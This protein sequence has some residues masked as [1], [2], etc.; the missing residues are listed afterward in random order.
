[1]KISMTP[2]HPGRFI[3]TE[4]LEELGLS[5]TEAAEFMG[6][7]RSTFSDLLHQKAALSP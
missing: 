7:R 5:V 1:M 6:V 4:I 3:K 2:S